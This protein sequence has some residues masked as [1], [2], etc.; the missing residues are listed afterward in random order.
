MISLSMRKNRPKPLLSFI[1]I[2][3]MARLTPVLLEGRRI[4]LAVLP[5]EEHG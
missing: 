5:E 2:I 3:S 4:V 1:A